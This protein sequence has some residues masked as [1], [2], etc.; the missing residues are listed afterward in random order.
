M[1]GLSGV[2]AEYQEGHCNA[3]I[4]KQRTGFFLNGTGRSVGGKEL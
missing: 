4:V 3:G 1:E 2:Q